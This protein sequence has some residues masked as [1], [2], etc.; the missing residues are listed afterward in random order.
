MP[1]LLAW[2]VLLCGWSKLTNRLSEIRCLC[3]F[4]LCTT[5]IH[6]GPI[7]SA[8]M[9]LLLALGW[10]NRSAQTCSAGRGS[11]TVVRVRLALSMGLLVCKIYMS[12][13]EDNHLHNLL[14]PN[15]LYT[16]SSRGHLLASYTTDSDKIEWIPTGRQSDDITQIVC[17]PLLSARFARS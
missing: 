14:C 10:S 16:A 12:F 6:F 5:R 7:S 15:G 17:V 11:K 9:H 1:L 13:T 8:D 4:L 2:V 3:L